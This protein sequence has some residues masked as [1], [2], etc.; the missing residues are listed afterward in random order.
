V[1]IEAGEAEVGH[2]QIA[3]LPERIIGGQDAPGH[4]VEK[5]PYFLPIHRRA[6]LALPLRKPWRSRVTKW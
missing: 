5:R 1:E 2:G 6:S 3:E 4:V